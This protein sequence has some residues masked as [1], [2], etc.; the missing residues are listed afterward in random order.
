MTETNVSTIFVDCGINGEQPKNPAH[1][2][3]PVLNVNYLPVDWHPPKTNEFALCFTSKHSFRSFIE[4]ILL[5]NSYYK[6]NWKIC[7]Y[8]CAVG[9][10][11]ALIVKNELPEWMNQNL[12]EIIYPKYENGLLPLLKQLNDILNPSCSLYIFTSQIGI[13]KKIV[14]DHRL[15]LYYHRGCQY[16]FS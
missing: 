5:K 10:N 15:E 4:K 12:N 7:N 13:S 9:K 16:Y 3:F 8:I 2:F 14:F 1:L 6:K 11:T